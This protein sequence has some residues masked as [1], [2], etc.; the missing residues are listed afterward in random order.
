MRFSRID[1]SLRKLPRASDIGTFT[2]QDLSVATA[3]NGGDIGTETQFRVRHGFG[4][5]DAEDGILVFLI[6]PLQ[7]GCGFQIHSFAS[8]RQT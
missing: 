2:Y 7:D 1:S 3:Q 8:F 6:K 5:F 4:E